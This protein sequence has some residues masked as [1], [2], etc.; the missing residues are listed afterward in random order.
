MEPISFIRQGAER[1][2]MPSH[3]AS[4]GT[5]PMGEMGPP[6]A[7]FSRSPDVVT[8]RLWSAK[9][10]TRIVPSLQTRKTGQTIPYSLK[11]L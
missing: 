2:A 5:T 8:I 1:G 10:K 9:T 11:A 7:G 4:F 6:K 3:R